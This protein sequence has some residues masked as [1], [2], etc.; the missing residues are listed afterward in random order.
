MAKIKV[1]Y[2]AVNSLPAKIEIENELKEFQRLVEGHIE[3]IILS[4]DLCL[5]CNEEG[6]INGMRINVYIHE[7]NQFIFGPYLLVGISGDSFASIP[8][9]LPDIKVSQM[10]ARIQ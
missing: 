2:V 6:R 10:I 4:P 8:K 7:I 5:V 3:T 9:K 1:V